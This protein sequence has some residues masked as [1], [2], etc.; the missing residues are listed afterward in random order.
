LDAVLLARALSRGF[1]MEDR[2]IVQCL[3]ECEQQIIERSSVKVKASAEAAKFLH[4]EVAVEVGN[5]TR[6]G[7]ARAEKLPGTP[8]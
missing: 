6:G 8:P 7:A 4:T 3:A 2:D 1:N 5:V